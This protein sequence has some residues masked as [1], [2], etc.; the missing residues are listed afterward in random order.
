MPDFDEIEM[1]DYTVKLRTSDSLRRAVNSLGFFEVIPY[2]ASSD[3]NLDIRFI[4]P[5]IKDTK[6]VKDVIK[7][8][9]V[10]L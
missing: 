1:G 2:F 8:N 6:S 9:C 4:M 7:F 5:K 3:I 10:S